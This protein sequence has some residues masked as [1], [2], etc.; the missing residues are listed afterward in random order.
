MVMGPFLRRLRSTVFSL[1]DTSHVTDATPELIAAMAHTSFHPNFGISAPLPVRE[2]PTNQEGGRVT[3]GKYV[4][5]N[6]AVEEHR[7]EDR[8]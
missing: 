5:L 2:A 7:N 8:R 1:P 3:P 4:V 6:L